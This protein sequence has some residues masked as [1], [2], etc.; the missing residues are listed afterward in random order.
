MKKETK[1]S[2]KVLAKE[3][4]FDMIRLSEITS[5]NKKAQVIRKRAK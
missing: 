1:K 4:D 3:N 5:A 2:K